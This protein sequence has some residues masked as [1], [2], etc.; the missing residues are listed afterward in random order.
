MVE[1]LRKRPKAEYS[2]RDKCCA[3]ALDAGFTATSQMTVHEMARVMDVATRA[4]M[5]GVRLLASHERVTLMQTLAEILDEM[6]LL[7]D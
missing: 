1:T 6:G 3:M 4:K 2:L 5:I 7:P